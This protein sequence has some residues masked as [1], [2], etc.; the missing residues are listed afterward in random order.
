MKKMFL[1]LSVICVFATATYAQS[2][3]EKEVADAV[4]F[5]RKAMISGNKAD[6][7]KVACEKLSYGHSSGKIQNA[8]EFV[9]TIASKQSVFVTIELS[10]QTIKIVD[11]TAIVRHILT[12]QTND[13]GK[14]G[15]VNLGIMLVFV[16]EH[17]NWKL[18][19]RQAY[20]LLV[21]TPAA[22]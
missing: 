7:E 14:P 13:G 22:Q 10:N 3:S 17:G 21:P 19:G 20:K 11:N 8:D 4:E 16:K 1:L 2:K 6:L 9:E 12:A 18:V 15:N 5:M